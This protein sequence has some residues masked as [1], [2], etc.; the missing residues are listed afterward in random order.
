VLHLAAA[1]LT[2]SVDLLVMAA[3]PWQATACFFLCMAGGGAVWTLVTSELLARLPQARA[4]FAA[5]VLT[6]ALSMANVV[7]QPLIGRVVDA[8]GR[9]DGIAMALAVW[10]VPGSLVWFSRGRIRAGTGR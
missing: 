8:T 2:A 7:A 10:V 1:T 5:G 4:S 3:A 9:Y 6:G